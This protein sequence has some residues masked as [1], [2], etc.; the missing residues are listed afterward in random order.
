MG[1]EYGAK[2]LYK[3]Y[4][5]P[6]LDLTFANK[7]SLVDRISGNNLITFTRASTAT[8]VGADGLIKSAAVNEPRF[9]HDPTTGESLGLLVEEARTNGILY[10]GSISSSTRIPRAS[11]IT[12]NIIL[13]PNG[14][15]EG[16]K[17]AESTSSTRFREM[18]YTNS[19]TISP[20]GTGNITVSIFVKKGERDVIFMGNYNST[21]SH[22]IGFNL[23]TETFFTVS[24]Y[25]PPVSYNFQRFPGGW[26][27]I[28]Y[29]VNLTVNS[30]P[31]I[32]V[33][34]GIDEQFTSYTGDGSS[35]IYVWGQCVE[36]GSFPT[37]YIP[38]TT[39]TVT[40]AA[41]VA[42]MTG[43]NFSSWYNQG[44]GTWLANIRP[45]GGAAFLEV[46]DNGPIIQTYA[47]GIYG[48]RVGA[49]NIFLNLTTPIS[50]AMGYTQG[51]SISA[52]S[53]GSSPSTVATSLGS[54]SE[55]HIGRA[56][57]AYT[58]HYVNGTGCAHFPRLTYYPVRLPDA[59]LQALTQ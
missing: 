58:S 4:G 40:R 46:F 51:V 20:F 9:D 49:E 59:T 3:A 52:S 7:K 55:L 17:L 56:N 23:T 53:R 44:Q 31:R 34:T 11:I 6:A 45:F 21:P 47:G 19:G 30:S 16:A 37:S 8:Y 57:N 25:T 38:T 39:A 27:R 41:D 22:W 29:T 33:T 14:S 18:D 2:N 24:G 15:L 42:S 50:V 54:M 10:S 48:L 12:E 43:T 32:D 26:Y 36:K 13:A 5:V 1:I 28:W 35:G